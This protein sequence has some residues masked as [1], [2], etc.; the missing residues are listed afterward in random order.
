M[1]QVFSN[2]AISQ[3]ASPILSTDTTITVTPLDGGKFQSPSAGQYEL[4][5]LT[6]GVNWE[7][8]KCTSRVNDTFTVERGFEGIARDWSTG[9]VVKST[10]TKATLENL[11]QIGTYGASLALFNYQNFR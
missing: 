3:T 7:I 11:V 8:V 2:Y 9:T 5:T 1:A 4:L 10:V 6:D